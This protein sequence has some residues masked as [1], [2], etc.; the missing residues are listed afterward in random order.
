MCDV[1]AQLMLLS[2]YAFNMNMFTL[3]YTFVVKASP[4]D[5]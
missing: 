3:Y 2:S 4:R 1:F 5:V